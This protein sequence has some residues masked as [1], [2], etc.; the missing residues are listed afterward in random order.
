MSRVSPSQWI[1]L[2]RCVACIKQ[3]S[4]AS[5][6]NHIF[7]PSPKSRKSISQFQWHP[8]SSETS[9]S[10]SWQTYRTPRNVVRSWSRSLMVFSLGERTLKNP[11]CVFYITLQTQTKRSLISPTPITTQK[12]TEGLET[13]V[14]SG[15]NPT[16]SMLSHAR[17][18]YRHHHDQNE[19]VFGK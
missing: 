16:G 12:T 8:G 18:H 11:R 9:W 10:G 15:S 6:K 3:H 17:E 2:L 13:K 5:Q 1:T 14:R 7:I 19:T 4:C